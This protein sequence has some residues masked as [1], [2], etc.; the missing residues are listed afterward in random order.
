MGRKVFKSHKKAVGG[1]GK[2]LIWGEVFVRE[3]IFKSHKKWLEEE[4]SILS[5]GKY[6]L[7]RKYLK[8]IKSGW[9][10]RQVFLS[11]GKYLW[12][13]EYLKVIKRG[14]KRKQ[15]FY[16]GKDV[17]AWRKRYEENH[18]LLLKEESSIFSWENICVERKVFQNKVFF[19]QNKK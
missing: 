10:R 16:P 9:R 4:A 14:W 15:V 1:G 11:W 19:F 13:R 7:G 18:K 17:F 8:V 12:G 5:G 2:Y 3:K 6:L